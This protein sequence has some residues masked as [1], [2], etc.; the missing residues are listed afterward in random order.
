MD[1]ALCQHGM[2]KRGLAM[3]VPSVGP[4][5]NREKF[6]AAA[7]MLQFVV[8]TT[9]K[10][11]LSDLG[12]KVVSRPRTSLTLYQCMKETLTSS[13]TCHDLQNG[14]VVTRQSPIICQPS[15][16]ANTEP[17]LPSSP[18]LQLLI[19]ANSKS[20][21]RITPVSASAIQLY[22]PPPPRRMNT[23]AQSL[24]PSK[25]KEIRRTCNITATRS[26]AHKHTHPLRTWAVHSP[27]NKQTQCHTHYPDLPCCAPVPL[28][29]SP[30]GVHCQTDTQP[31]ANPKAGLRRT[32][33]WS[34]R[35]PALAQTKALAK[36]AGVADTSQV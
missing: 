9:N 32:C 6:T 14:P 20:I 12:Q 7:R 1:N 29:H 13:N 25:K 3:H 18:P 17:T 19:T 28:I 15:T 33:R 10:I 31:L 4:C 23:P 5:R 34:P 11:P 2:D 26:C 21:P 35:Q 16:M 36:P 27:P 22:C 8:S 30:L 24:P